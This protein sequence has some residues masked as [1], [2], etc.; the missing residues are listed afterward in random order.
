MEKNE[1]YAVRLFIFEY[2]D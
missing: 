1:T 2:R